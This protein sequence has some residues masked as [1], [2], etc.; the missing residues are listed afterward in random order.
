MTNIL[1]IQLFKI[2]HHKSMTLQP[3]KFWK[4]KVVQVT[5][6]VL[7]FLTMMAVT[8]LLN[9]KNYIRN[10]TRKDMIYLLML[11]MSDG[12]KYI[13][14]IQAF[15]QIVHWFV[16]FSQILFQPVLLEI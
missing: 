1:V 5:N 6:L 2:Y 14:Q 10:D 9:K 7:H 13:T 8:L 11:T 16:I 15:L 4:Q 3:F 12:S